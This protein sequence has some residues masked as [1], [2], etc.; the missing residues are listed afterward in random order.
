MTPVEIARELW[1]R[2]VLELDAREWARKTAPL[3]VRASAGTKRVLFCEAVWMLATS[4]VES[5]FA[6][7]LAREGY[8]S[9]LLLPARNRAVERA[10]RATC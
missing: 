4:K 2:A 6:A 8:E 9:H 10:F 5:L 1:R 3:A 7:G